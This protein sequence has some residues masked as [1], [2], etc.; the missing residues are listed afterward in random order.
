MCLHQR[1][2]VISGERQELCEGA[3]LDRAR[4]VDLRPIRGQEGHLDQ[5]L[6]RLER[7]ED[8]DLEV[9]LLVTKRTP[10]WGPLAC[11]KRQ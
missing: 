5:P 10:E 2:K 6:P 11:D 1:V 8:T 4:A 3:A 9:G 7:G